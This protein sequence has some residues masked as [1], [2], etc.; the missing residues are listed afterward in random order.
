MHNQVNFLF[1][2]NQHIDMNREEI[3]KKIEILFGAG[4]KSDEIKKN[5]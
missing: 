2:F 5:P 3:R 4:H 1:I